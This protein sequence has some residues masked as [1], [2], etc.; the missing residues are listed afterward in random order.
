M[1]RVD[2]LD[3]PAELEVERRGVHARRGRHIGAEDAHAEPA[4]AAEGP[5]SVSVTPGELDR[6][7]PVD[8]NSELIRSQGPTPAPGREDDG[9]TLQRMSPSLEPAPRRVGRQAADV[10]AGDP[11]AR[12]EPLGRPREDEPQD[13]SEQGRHSERREDALNEQP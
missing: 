3:H 7:T 10:D 13:Q 6:G 2:R 12:G 1:R 9:N 11:H 5:E 8:A 4:E